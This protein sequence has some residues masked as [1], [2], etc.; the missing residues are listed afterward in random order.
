MRRGGPV[1]CRV[2]WPWRVDPLGIF[3]RGTRGSVTSEI[4]AARTMI[5]IAVEGLKSR[6]RAGYHILPQNCWKMGLCPIK[7]MSRKLERL[8]KV[9]LVHNQ[10]MQIKHNCR[11][12]ETGC[13]APQNRS[14][15]VL[16]LISLGARSTYVIRKQAGGK[17]LKRQKPL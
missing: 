2:I 5:Q 6:I 10:K 9:F 16:I 3:H 8:S 17:I 11:V 15:K 12:G 1:G 14:A 7:D 13:F 4:K